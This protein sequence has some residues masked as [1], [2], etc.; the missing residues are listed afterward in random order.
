MALIKA[1]SKGT[2]A[3]HL[4]TLPPKHVNSDPL[5]VTDPGWKNL[6]FKKV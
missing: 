6:G 3:Y 4:R 1:I 5:N 2:V